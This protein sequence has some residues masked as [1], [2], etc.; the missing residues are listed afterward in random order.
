M[1]HDGFFKPRTASSSARINIPHGSWIQGESDGVRYS[2][3]PILENAMVVITVRA[4]YI[5]ITSTL[6]F[7][8]IGPREREREA[9]RKMHCRP[10]ID[11]AH[12]HSLTTIACIHRFS[13]PTSLTAPVTTLQCAWRFG[14][15]GAWHC[16]VGRSIDRSLAAHL[17]PSS[18]CAYTGTQPQKRE[19]EWATHTRDKA[20]SAASEQSRAE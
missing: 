15:R 19:R 2:S 5:F 3:M 13:R 4:I 1:K 11:A 7:Y 12:T 17:A 6:F 20:R 18:V 16:G 8:F 10:L 9:G 14:S